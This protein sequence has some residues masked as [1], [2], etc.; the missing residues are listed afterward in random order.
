M[1]L[2]KTVFIVLLLETLIV[3][4]L[5]VGAGFIFSEEPDWALINPMLYKFQTGLLYFFN[6][7]INKYVKS[8]QKL[9]PSSSFPPSIII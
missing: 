7:A 2:T 5:C 4:G 6:T 9:S 8:L 3:F 1:K